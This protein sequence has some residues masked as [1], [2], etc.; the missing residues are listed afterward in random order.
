M[1]EVG[2][3]G[4]PGSL[5]DGLC[6]CSGLCLAPGPVLAG[7]LR[8]PF[9]L[10]RVNPGQPG[11]RPHPCWRISFPPPTWPLIWAPPLGEVQG[12]WQA[13]QLGVCLGPSPLLPGCPPRSKHSDT[14]E[15][16]GLAPQCSALSH[17]RSF[18]RGFSPSILALGRVSREPRGRPKGR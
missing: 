9:K 17:L 18:R 11:G 5:T 12:P 8:G 2:G 7:S 1:G 15:G 4:A 3:G 6:D 14:R 16:G 10:L 13:A